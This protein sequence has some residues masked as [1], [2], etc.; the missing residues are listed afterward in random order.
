MDREKRDSNDIRLPK[1][2]YLRTEIH[3]GIVRI[4]ETLANITVPHERQFRRIEVEGNPLA[5]F[6]I[7]SMTY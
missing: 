1:L 5:M 4:L 2:E 7:F 3:F 6:D